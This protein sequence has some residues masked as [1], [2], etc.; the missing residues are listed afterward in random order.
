MLPGREQSEPVLQAKDLAKAF[1]GVQALRGAQL[2][3]RPGTVHALMGENGAGK[4][5]LLKLLA[6]LLQPDAGEILFEGRPIKL[7]NP[8][9]ALRHGIVMIHQELMPFPH[10]SVAENIFIGSEPAG[11]LAG[12]IDRAR[13][14]REAQ[15][16]LERV[17]AQFAPE[18]PMGALS[19]AGMQL[20][21]IARALVHRVRVLILDEPTSALSEREV[22]S[23][24][25]IVRELKREGVAIVYISHKFAEVFALADEVTVL[26]DGA[27]VGTQ[28]AASLTREELIRLMVGRELNV[29]FPPRVPPSEEVLLEARGLSAPPKFADVSFCLRRG[30]ILGVAGLMGAGRTQVANALYGLEPA[31]SGVLLLRGEPVKIRQPSDAIARG[32]GMVGEDRKGFGLVLGLPVQHNVTLAALRRCGRGPLISSAEERRLTDEQIEAFNIRTPSREQPVERLSGGN[33]QKVVIARALLTEPEILILDEPTR[34]IDIGA[35]AEVYAW[36]HKLAAQGKAILL[37]SSELPEILGLSHRILVMRAGRVAAELDPRTATQETILHAA[38]Q[39]D[40][41]NL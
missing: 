29:L 38:M 32:I 35:K 24:F 26:R 20:V 18:Q 37:I 27:Y 34:G 36:I 39:P 4:S 33:Q 10:L 19:V 22:E 41:Q 25:R 17:G 8:H 9:E 7:R 13:M 30:E 11:A 16:L 15:A 2:S 23:L 5:T 21:E 28:P 31:E 6:G 12:T 14:N 3:L 40:A 1:G